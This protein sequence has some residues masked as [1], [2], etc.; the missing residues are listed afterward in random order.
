MSEVVPQKPVSNKR[1]GRNKLAAGLVAAGLGV[2]LAGSSKAIDDYYAPPR[3][4][5][6]TVDVADFLSGIPFPILPEI[7]TEV[8]SMDPDKP[9]SDDVL[10]TRYHTFIHDLPDVKLEIMPEAL[11]REPAFSRVR[12][13]PNSELHI[14]F[15]DGPFVDSS[16]IPEEINDPRLKS[17]LE[18]EIKNKME[19]AGLIRPLLVALATDWKDTVGSLMSEGRFGDL[20]QRQ[21]REL[22]VAIDK[23]IEL[24]VLQPSLDDSKREVAAQGEV[25]ETKTAVNGKEL[26]RTYV[27][28]SA[29]LES[30]PDTVRL[31]REIAALVRASGNADLKEVIDSLLGSGA[32]KRSDRLVSDLLDPRSIPVDMKASTYPIREFSLGELFRHEMKH[33]GGLRHPD[34][35]FA[36]LDDLYDASRRYQAGEAWDPTASDGR[37]YYFRITTPDGEFNTQ[38]REDD[39]KERL[40]RLS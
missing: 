34:T 29:R 38:R 22:L 9:V 11:V 32:A 26:T 15:L 36:V 27:L 21:T 3:M 16:Y 10:R 35:D 17:G 30:V 18:S 31:Q 28:V 6:N 8:A 24:L 14:V 33:A 20:S 4:S 13:L 25:F 12:S 40:R 19:M 1:L 23:Y 7:V 5:T 39:V 37:G 2:G